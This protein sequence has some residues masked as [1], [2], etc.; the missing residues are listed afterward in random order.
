ML[1]SSDFK[2]RIQNFCEETQAALNELSR[3]A[4]NVAA[5]FIGMA[6]AAESKK[7]NLG[8]STKNISKSISGDK[9]LNLTDM[10]GLGLRL[11]V[12]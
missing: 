6:V 3:P 11:K 5:P 12:N 8:Q 10:H 1:E 2:K 4:V 9:I 7:P